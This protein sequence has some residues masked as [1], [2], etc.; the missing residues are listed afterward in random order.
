MKRVFLAG[1]IAFILFFSTAAFAKTENLLLN[2]GFEYVTASG[3]PEKWYVT[4]Y[5]SQEG[6]SRLGITSEKAHSGQYSAVIENASSNDA[7]F[8]C[9][10]KVKPESL[11]KLSGYVYV[12]HMEDTG[13]GANFGIE[14]I[15]SF[16]E[17][18]FD[19][20]GDW[21]YL[22]WY[23]ETGEDQNEVTIGIRVG[24]YSAESVGKAYFDDIVLEEVDSLPD[25]VIAALWYSDPSY[26][27]TASEED[28]TSA[29]KNTVLFICIAACYLVLVGYFLSA[30]LGGKRC[31]S[32]QAPVL[33]IGLF[34]AALVRILLAMY[35]EG[36]S[37]DINCFRAWSMRMADAGPLHFYA[38]DYFCDYPPGAMLLLWPIG[39]LLKN[40][41]SGE[42]VLLAVKLLPILCDFA[43]ATLV[44]RYSRKHI[45][46][47][48]SLAAALLYL[49]NPA[50]LVTGAGWGQMDSVL[51]FLIVVTA[52]WAM[53]RKWYLA[54]PMFVISALVKPQ[55]LLFAP[56]GGSI[57]F[58]DV[59]SRKED[60]KQI[61]L[62]AVRGVAAALLAAAAIVFPFAIEQEKPVGW[63]WT[64]YGQTLGSYSYATLNTANLYYLLGA[65]WTS[66]S[67]KVPDILLVFSAAIFAAGA[68]VLIAPK[69]KT[70]FATLKSKIKWLA[71]LFGVYSVLCTVMLLQKVNY[72][73]YGYA[74]LALA[75]LFALIC[76]LHDKQ[77]ESLTFYMALALIGVYVLSVKVHERYLFPALILLLLSYCSSK[78]RRILW[79]FAG[80]S[81]TTFINT[82][83][84]LDNSILFGAEYGHLNQDTFL[85]NNVLSIANIG[86]CGFAWWIGI[87]GIRAS[88]EQVKRRRENVTMSDDAT[89]SKDVYRE[90][91]LKS[92]DHRLNL[93]WRDYLIISITTAVYAVL[94]F[95]HLGSTV[96]PQT[97]WVSTSS[98]EAV[99]LEL[100][101]TA[102]FSVLYYAG[103]S[104]NDF[105]I[106]VSED[107]TNWSE[108]YP[109]QMREGLCYRWNYA[110]HSQTSNGKTTYSANN[111]ANV[112]WLT[113]K[114]LK[115]N[116]CK[117]GLNLW[118]V[119]AR[120]E[121]GNN[122]TL[123]VVSTE[124]AQPELLNVSKPASNLVDET[125]TCV[126]EPGWFNGTYF[127]EIY[128][129][130]TA[131]E[132]LHAQAPY[133]TTHPPLGKLLMS[134]AIAIFGM[135]PF[136]WR[137]AGALIG[138]LMLPALYL[139]AMQLTHKR[140]V[141]TVSMLALTF[142]LM[143]FTQTRIA[144][145]DSFPVFF[146][147]LTYLFMVRYM[148]MDAFAVSNPSKP[149]LMDKT[150]IKTL[151]PLCLCGIC[152]GLSIASKWI[153]IYSAVGLAVL[154]F[155]TQYRYLRVND[156]AWELEVSSYH[157]NEAGRIRS[158]Q[159]FTV[160][161]I[162]ITCGFC[163]IFF[164]L[165]PAA[166]YC[167]CYIP[168]LAPTGPVTLKR[169]IAA[170]KG[171]FNYHSQPGLGADH[172]FQS[173]WWQW[174]LILKPMWY[175]QDT[176]EPAG[177]Q[178][179]ILCFGNPWIFYIGAF[180]MAALLICW[181]TKYIRIRN[182][183]P[184]LKRGDGNLTF[185]YVSIGFLVQYLPWVLVPRSMY[186]Y[187]YF[188]SVPFIILATAILIERF[189]RKQ[190][191]F[192]WIAAGL[193]VTGAIAFFIMFFPYASGR[194]TSVAW[195]DAMK[196]FPRLYY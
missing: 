188:A 51:A 85:L 175:A 84:V 166:I 21:K 142:D 29:E 182:R 33:G 108:P 35:V 40:A 193:Y 195:L 148:Q 130:R 140:S 170:Q 153:G 56:V 59:F 187:H 141:A 138:V 63:L 191:T 81:V 24:G 31:T 55:A 75:Y 110:V 67:Q 92:R 104:Y 143:H 9:T 169:I 165:I 145:I 149:K 107:G 4:S 171:M 32:W 30:N 27:Q 69:T 125:A 22:E 50:V 14:G 45:S 76:M 88:K 44:W 168:Y 43:G 6:Y 158:A 192:W 173:P 150:Y 19:T 48:G 60:R 167:L 66:L 114:Y 177:Y 105:S 103:V 91:L 58:Y 72:S 3:M 135:T 87:T 196:W 93:N 99:V 113:G 83:I 126:G 39:F 47:T 5:R 163:L 128:H 120:D 152:M 194:L 54:I 118:E 95:S 86:L 61:L 49:F 41:S 172:P 122:L 190:R 12:E 160:H 68:L 178:S 147:L 77:K 136:G 134:A 184:V 20:A 144:T 73:V 18:L 42:T 116:A 74:M 70:I 1:W 62:Q 137:F 8:T 109:C 17:G 161:R 159:S 186:I 16:S 132:H 123:N 112:L 189:T 80:F 129:A 164:I 157:P 46:S 139:L 180:A 90:M 156:T 64:L 121:T 176:F 10:V 97:A 102:T 53:E 23:G 115:V 26:V 57:F 124:N 13:N 89:P 162:A 174:P 131:Y 117:A 25:E 119:V 82:V 179:T 155:L 94:A 106:Q 11:Y 127:D 34:L 154:F 146:I 28:T 111:S 78:D 36:Y 2:S 65:N 38:P 185:A 71:V 151:V 181:I 101:D 133:E 100:D 37:V 7:R 15:Y 52:L 79:L 96:A 98:E 183:K